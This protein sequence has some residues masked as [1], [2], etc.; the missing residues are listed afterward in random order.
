[1]YFK[2]FNTSHYENIR[3]E[4]ENILPAEFLQTTKLGY[5]NNSVRTTDMILSLDSINQLINDLSLKHTD[6]ALCGFTVCKPNQGLPIHVDKGPFCLSMN[7]PITYSKGTFVNFY[8][9]FGPVSVINNG[10]NIYYSVKEENCKLVE[11]LETDTP[12]IIDTTVPHKVINNTEHTRVML[13][14]RFIPK[15][16]FS[17]FILATDRGIEPL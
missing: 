17:D 1:M 9:N 13:L 5:I 6:I 14:M 7:I 16:K 4:I 11:T 12:C 15:I 2:K 10:S 3:Q 8:D